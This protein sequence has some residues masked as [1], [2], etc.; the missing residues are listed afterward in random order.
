M[1]RLHRIK[2][3]KLKFARK[4]RR[5]L[6]PPE[7]LLWARIRNRQLG[8]FKFR[9]Q[10]PIGKYI[11]DFCCAENKLI[12]ELDGDSHADQIEY[13]EKRTNDLKQQGYT[14]IRFTNRNVKN[15]LENVIQTIWNECINREESK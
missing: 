13:D 12:I 5:P 14:V 15:G 8:G 10:H 3:S 2:P 7:Q 11:A 9:R 1:S 6:T 4:L